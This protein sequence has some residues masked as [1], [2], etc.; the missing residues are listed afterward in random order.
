MFH[1]ININ[2]HCWDT[3][4][5]WAKQDNELGVKYHK[6]VE[7][8]TKECG[9]ITI[10]YPLHPPT[11]HLLKQMQYDVQENEQW[12]QHESH[13]NK[14]AC[15]SVLNT[16]LNKLLYGNVST[17]PSKPKVVHRRIP[18]K[19]NRYLHVSLKIQNGTSVYLSKKLSLKVKF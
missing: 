14:I 2:L 11:E 12:K 9:V 16:K 7:S 5:L 4:R 18:Q 19:F 6:S 1:S 17:Y 3:M 15:F 10:N 8:M 13:L